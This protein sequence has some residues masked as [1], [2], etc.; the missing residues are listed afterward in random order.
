MMGGHGQ[1]NATV[2]SISRRVDIGA[3]QQYAQLWVEDKPGRSIQWSYSE[4]RLATEVVLRSG[5][6]ESTRWITDE[7]V[8]NNIINPFKEYIIDMIQGLERAER[9]QESA[10][11]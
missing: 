3:A 7:E 4:E 10:H 6:L 2:R 5:T 8:S 1:L 11:E 9:R